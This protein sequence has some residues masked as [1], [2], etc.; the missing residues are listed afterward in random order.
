[1][2]KY[3]VGVVGCGRI[4]WS[5][6]EDSLVKQPVSHM[7]AYALNKQT[8]VI[9]VC[10]IVGAK[11]RGAARRYGA[12]KVYTDYRKMLASEAFD[13]LS[14]CTSTE[15]HAAICIAAAK[16]G[17]RAIFCEKPIAPSL[18]DADRMIRICKRY[19]T[20]LV[21]NHTRRWD[22]SYN[23]AKGLLDHRV[24]GDVN[25]ITAFCPAGLLNSGTHLFD[26]LCQLFGGVAAVSGSII[27]DRST[28]PGARGMLRFKNGPFCFI[29]SSFRD[30]VLFG[31]TIIG[32]RGMLE[33]GG[34]VRSKEIYRFFLGRK[35]KHESGIKELTLKRYEPPKWTP[36]IMI[37]VSNIVKVLDGRPAVLCTGEDGRSALEIAMA[38]HESSGRGGKEVVLPLRQRDR[39]VIPRKTSFTEDGRLQ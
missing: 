16:A 17:V 5:F 29:D 36:P 19:G 28:D 6:N 37:A 20:T 2:R 38:F 39:S 25:L 18:D 10:D 1:M 15:T 26:M 32:D 4:G 33:L 9:A 14:I 27:P 3:K 35:S 8:N 11:A 12:C 34:N 31:A 7:S 23:K 22:A 30:F 13:I 21:V 24:I